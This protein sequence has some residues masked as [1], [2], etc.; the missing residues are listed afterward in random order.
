[1]TDVIEQIKAE[2]KRQYEEISIG[3]SEYDAGYENGRAQLCHELLAFIYRLQ[4][5][6]GIDTLEAKEVDLEKEIDNY[7]NPIEAWQIQEAPFSSME[8]IARH[9]FELGLKTQ[10]GG[11]E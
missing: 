2:I 7:L 3:L 4:K 10:K 1:M 8:K 9:F 6:G 11:E 5:E